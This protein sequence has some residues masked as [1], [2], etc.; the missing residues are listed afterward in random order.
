MTRRTRRLPP[1]E[2]L[3]PLLA[4]YLLLATLYA[5]QAWRRET[6]TLFSDEIEFTQISRSIADTGRAALRG[7]EP[8]PGA[9]L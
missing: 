8:A 2:T 9:S 1:V 3:L 5:W 6:P 7:G 4:A